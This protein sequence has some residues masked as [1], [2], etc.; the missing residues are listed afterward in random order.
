MGFVGHPAQSKF[1]TASQIVYG[2][3]FGCLA[4]RCVAFVAVSII[5]R[6]FGKFSGKEFCCCVHS[7]RT[8]HNASS[9]C[10]SAIVGIGGGGSRLRASSHSER[11]WPR[12]SRSGSEKEKGDRGGASACGSPRLL[13]RPA[14]FGGSR[15]VISSMHAPG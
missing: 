15:Q 3:P 14:T 4:K 6:D 8:A 7:P 13:D 1:P 2:S 10:R 9:R 5:G 12:L 11:F